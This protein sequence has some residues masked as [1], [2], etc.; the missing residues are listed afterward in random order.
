MLLQAAV[1]LPTRAASTPDQLLVL[2]AVQSVPV[3]IAA[4]KAEAATAV[5]EVGAA[6]P[7]T[8]GQPLP[9]FLPLLV[10]GHRPRQ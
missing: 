10:R 3:A 5:L 7:L 4:L 9:C 6:T 8:A 1:V 2:P